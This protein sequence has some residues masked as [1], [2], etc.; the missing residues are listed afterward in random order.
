MPF[1]PTTWVHPLVQ[2]EGTRIKNASPSSTRFLCSLW[3]HP[4]TSHALRLPRVHYSARDLCYHRL[5]RHWYF[6]DSEVASVWKG[7][8]RAARAISY[9]T[10]NG[11]LSFM[12]RQSTT[13]PVCPTIQ[14]PLLDVIHSL[15]L[16]DFGPLQHKMSRGHT[17]F[18]SSSTLL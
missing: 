6:R 7:V 16:L 17:C 12:Q 3:G 5:N 11:Q 18:C 15:L 14:K 9:A 10:L 8:R 1:S 13:Y 2:C 4:G